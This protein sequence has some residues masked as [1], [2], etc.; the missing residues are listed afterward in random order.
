MSC[1]KDSG[2]SGIRRAHP[3]TCDGST[4]LEPD[5]LPSELWKS[6]VLIKVWKCIERRHA[7]RS[8]SVTVVP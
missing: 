6:I 2:T 4:V 1:I 5:E 7:V 8:D 3:V